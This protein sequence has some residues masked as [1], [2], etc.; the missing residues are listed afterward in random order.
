M[1]RIPKIDWDEPW[2]RSKLILIALPFGLFYYY[3][4]GSLLFSKLP[5]IAKILYFFIV[6]LFVNI[7]LAIYEDKIGSLIGWSKQNELEY[8]EDWD[9]RKNEQNNS[10]Q[11]MEIDLP[12]DSIIV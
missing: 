12:S 10:E 5:L 11:T 9:T 3:F 4:L 8:L 6:V 1:V 2:A 7:T